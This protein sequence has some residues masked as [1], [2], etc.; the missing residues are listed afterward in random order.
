MPK[1]KKETKVEIYSPEVLEK[2]RKYLF[3]ICETKEELQA[4]LRAFLKVDLP[5]YIVDENSTSSPMDFVWSVYDVMRTNIGPKEHAVAAARGTMKTLTSAVIHFL[6]MVHFRRSCVQI[7][8]IKPQ[9]RFCLQYLSKFLNIPELLQYFETY[10]SYEY[11]LNNLPPN[12]LTSKS[13]ARVSVTAATLTAANGFRGSLIIRDETDLIKREILDEVSMVAEPTQ[14]GNAFDP[15]TISLSSRKT[16]SG[17]VQELIEKSELPENKDIIHL[18]KWSLADFM[19]RCE[20]SYHGPKNDTAYINDDTL[21][22]IWNKEILDNNPARASF[23]KIETFEKCRTCPAFLVCQTRAAKQKSNAPGLR[24]IT[25]VA[26][27]ISAVKEVTTIKAQL[28]NLEP[29]TTGL[30]FPLLSKGLHLKNPIDCFLFLSGNT[31][32]YDYAHKNIEKNYKKP[33]TKQDLYQYALKNGWKTSYG[34]DFG[35]TDPAVIVVVLYNQ[36]TNYCLILHGRHSPGYS[37]SQ[38]ADTVKTLECV[39]LQ[40]DLICPDM[41]DASAHTYF[42]SDGYQ[43]W[44]NKPRS[45]DTGVSQLRGL[46]WNPTTQKSHFA[47]AN[48]DEESLYIYDCMSK[49]SHKKNVTGSFDMSSYEDDEYTHPC[50]AIRYALEPYR[51]NIEAKIIAKMENNNTSN[52]NT[53]TQAINQTYRD[54]GV[55]MPDILGDAVLDAYRAAGMEKYIIDDP[56]PK[57]KADKKKSNF[58]FSF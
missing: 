33:P 52:H 56:G 22:I 44:R 14:C 6:A 20:P 8:A 30:V 1:K 58:K 11:I 46:M 53:V 18:H 26:G 10:S 5:D 40:P 3:N 31:D 7:S 32:W 24:K 4:F 34:I 57:K 35:F 42:A 36:R 2:R 38:W 23:R 37:N 13:D 51:V 49:W 15:I 27:R 9:S 16:N 47:I 25:F 39:T 19:K 28:L 48:F 12:S 55:T 45:I 29:E 17:P 50:D 41:A 43:V 21:Q 54:A